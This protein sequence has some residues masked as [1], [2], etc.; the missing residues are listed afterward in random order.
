MSPIIGIDLGTTTGWAIL[1]DD[2]YRIDSG[3]WHLP[4][5]ERKPAH[6]RFE[7]L[8]KKLRQL[9]L[10]NWPAD[11]PPPHVAY[12]RPTFFGHLAPALV[13]GG[14]EAVLL[15]ACSGLVLVPYHPIPVSHV[16]LAAIGRGRVKRV[17]GVEHDPKRGIMDAALDRWG[18]DD[19]GYNNDIQC[20]YPDEADALWTAE[21]CRLALRGGTLPWEHVPPAKTREATPR[22]KKPVP[23]PKYEAGEMLL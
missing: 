5:G 7:A 19:V 14:F 17:P 16:K 21:A 20:V 18:R 23:A 1:T 12:E 2:G 10:T 8:H 3:Y 22:R 11:S 6:L 13:F 9:I 15:L 4:A